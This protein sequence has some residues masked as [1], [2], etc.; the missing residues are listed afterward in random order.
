M[1]VPQAG[2]AAVHE[3]FG[4][5]VGVGQ[6]APTLEQAV[7]QLST[8]VVVVPHVGVDAVQVPFETHTGQAGPV[9]E[10]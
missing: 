1:V 10:H 5:Q 3:P 8:P 2:V 7:P 6:V 4:V 9:F